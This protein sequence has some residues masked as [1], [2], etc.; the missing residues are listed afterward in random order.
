MFMMREI[1]L[2]IICYETT[3]QKRHWNN[4][5]AIPRLKTIQKKHRTEIKFCIFIFMYVRGRQSKDKVSKILHSELVYVF[6]HKL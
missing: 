6:L 3:N 1:L 5:C 4:F 2:Q